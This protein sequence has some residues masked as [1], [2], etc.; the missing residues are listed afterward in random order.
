MCVCVC[1]C[2]FVYILYTSYTC[3]YICVCVCVV[4]WTFRKS[5]LESN[6]WHFELLDMFSSNIFRQYFFLFLALVV[7]YFLWLLVS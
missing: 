5:N 1:V 3:I 4:A 6:C 7:C 2:L